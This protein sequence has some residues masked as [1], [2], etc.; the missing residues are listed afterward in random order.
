[1]LDCRRRGPQPSRQDRSGGGI[2]SVVF[3]RKSPT[4]RKHFFVSIPDACGIR[5]RFIFHFVIRSWRPAECADSALQSAC[6]SSSMRAIVTNQQSSANFFCRKISSKDTKGLHNL[7]ERPIHIKM[8]FFDIIDQRHRWLMRMKRAIEFT[9]FG[10]E[11]ARGSSKETAW[12]CFASSSRA[13]TIQLR[14]IRANDHRWI[15]SSFDQQMRQQ[16]GR[17]AL[18]VGPCDRDSCSARLSPSKSLRI[19]HRFDFHRLRLNKFRVICGDGGG[20]DNQVNFGL[21]WKRR[22]ADRD[23]NSSSS[24]GSCCIACRLVASADSGSSRL[25][26]ECKSAG[27]TTSDTNKMDVATIKNCRILARVHR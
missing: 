4:P 16:C 9:C 27:S 14:T 18:A 10:D 12:N 2:E 21:Q 15:K 17:R 19:C 11:N 8:I 25:H 22:V 1:M 5:R 26:H 6:N 23:S 13:A 20:I 24:E 7:V 3:S